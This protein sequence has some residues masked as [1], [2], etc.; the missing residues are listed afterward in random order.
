MAG[1]PPLTAQGNLNRVAT[2]IVVVSQPQ[3]NANAANLG[4]SLAVVTFEGPFTDQI[5]TATGIVNSPKPFVMGQIVISLLRTQGL[6]AAWVTQL[7]AG[8]YLGTV[9]AYP[10]SNVFPAISLSNASI[11]ELDPGAFDGADPIVKA[12]VKGT[13][14]IN[15]GLWAGLT[16]SAGT[17]GT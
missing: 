4:K 2:H 11:T 6:S 14:Y 5:E 10:D 7:E 9:V 3:L 15:S 1:F 13:F 16:G 8:S 17:A 12:T